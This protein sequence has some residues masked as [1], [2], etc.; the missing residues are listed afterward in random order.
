M[1]GCSGESAAT[2]WRAAHD[3]LLAAPQGEG[4]PRAHHGGRSVGSA[5]TG[6]PVVH[7]PTDMDLAFA[8]SRLSGS[9]LDH[10]P[11]GIF[12]QVSA[13]SY[14]EAVREQID[15]TATDADLQA[16]LTGP[17]PWTVR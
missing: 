17:D 6:E 9:E 7:D 1:Y 8:L 4:P 12:R 16:L 15:N 13:P 14:D 10:T 11:I 5:T 2:P 3:A